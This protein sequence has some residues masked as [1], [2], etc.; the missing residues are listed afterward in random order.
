MIKHQEL[1]T[2]WYINV[3]TYIFTYIILA[4][5]AQEGVGIEACGGAEHQPGTVGHSRAGERGTFHSEVVP[6]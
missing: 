6:P 1:C 2:Y 3:Y 4:H 5:I